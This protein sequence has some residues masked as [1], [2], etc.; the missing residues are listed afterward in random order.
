M[1]SDRE[2]E[3]AL[4]AGAPHGTGPGHTPEGDRLTSGGIGP[5]G[6]IGPQPE[7]QRLQDRPPEVNAASHEGPIS[8][9]P[10]TPSPTR[11]DG[12]G[13]AAAGPEADDSE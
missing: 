8:S 3:A 5:G 7:T 12:S 10:S 13:G 1:T 6:Q 11:E 9:S 4:P 2:A